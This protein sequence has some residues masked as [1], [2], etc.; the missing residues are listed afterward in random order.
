MPLIVLTAGVDYTLP[1]D[2]P[3]EAKAEIPRVRHPQWVHAH[4]ALAALSTR[5]VNR[6]L[7]D[8]PHYIHQYQ[9]QAVIDAIDEVVDEARARQVRKP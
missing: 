5:G 9:P 2:A 3:D 6:I 4:D 1:A 8:T 7:P